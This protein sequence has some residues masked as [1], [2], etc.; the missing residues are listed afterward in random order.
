MR[1]L[2]RF[3][4][5]HLRRFEDTPSA[6]L[7]SSVQLLRKE[8]VSSALCISTSWLQ[9]N[10]FTSVRFN[11]HILNHDER[12]TIPSCLEMGCEMV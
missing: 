7:L 3:T 8:A 4:I 6:N 11:E 5:P 9:D 12:L 1:T 10:R 2:D